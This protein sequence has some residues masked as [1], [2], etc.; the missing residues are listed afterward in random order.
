M[1][2]L[3]LAIFDILLCTEGPGL[4]L[5]DKNCLIRY[6]YTKNMSSYIKATSSLC[7]DIA[8]DND[9]VWPILPFMKKC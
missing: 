2:N 4:G 8:L 6:P 5:Y 7:V 1:D 9:P 3:E